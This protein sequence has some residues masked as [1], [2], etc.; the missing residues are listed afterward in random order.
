M[1]RVIMLADM[2]SFFAACEQAANPFLQNKPIAVCGKPNSRSVV[3]AA[4]YD[5]KRRGVKSGMSIIEAKKLCP[6]LILVPADIYKYTDTSL[7]A[8]SIFREYTLSL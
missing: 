5:A 7:K 4:S 3:A 8:L 6:E 2:D 1:E